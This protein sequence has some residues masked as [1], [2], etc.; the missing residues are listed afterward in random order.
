MNYKVLKSN[1]DLFQIYKK[2]EIETV[3]YYFEN[4]DY[5]CERWMFLVKHFMEYYP[6]VFAFECNE[7]TPEVI[8]NRKRI[9]ND[10]YL[11]EFKDLFEMIGKGKKNYHG[12]RDR[13]P[14]NLITD[15]IG[16]KFYDEFFGRKLKVITVKTTMDEALASGIREVIEVKEIEL[17]RYD[18]LQESI[19][20]LDEERR[21]EFNKEASDPTTP[22]GIYIYDIM[23]K[24]EKLANEHNVSIEDIAE[25]NGFDLSKIVISPLHTLS[26]QITRICIAT[27]VEHFI[28]NY[29]I[30]IQKLIN[31]CNYFDIPLDF[32]WFKN[33]G[34]A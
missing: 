33:G 31:L 21:E 10:K 29:E 30:E 13:L 6:E 27:E 12:S 11:D 3:R 9:Y 20:K 5:I 2:G 4:Y 7:T 23:N 28:S 34:N 25:K 32:F 19:K 14:S 22:S 18:E 17:K 1:M 15:E 24:I 26:S 8:E 16:Q